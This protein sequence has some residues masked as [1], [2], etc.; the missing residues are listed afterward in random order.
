MNRA[1]SLFR[2]PA[3]LLALLP[4][5]LTVLLAARP[6]A[7]QSVDVRLSGET[8]EQQATSFG[9]GRAFR[10]GS[11]VALRV[12]VAPS[13]DGFVGSAGRTVLVQW[14]V[15]NADGDI[16][17]HRRLVTLTPGR[18]R[19]TWLYAT[20]PRID[21][22]QLWTLRVF[23]APD[24]AGARGAEVGSRIID[25]PS[26]LV[27]IPSGA[28]AIGVIGTRTMGLGD[29]TWPQTQNGE[30]V[31]TSH[32]NV[33][34]QTFPPREIPDSHVGLGMYDILVWADAD[35]SE[36]TMDRQDALRNWIIGG[37]HLVIVLNQDADDW[38][39][40]DP[41]GSPLRGLVPSRPPTKVEDVS[42]ASLMST[43]T[44][45]EGE[46]KSRDE[47]KPT[48][49]LVFDRIGDE[50]DELDAGWIPLIAT[51]SGDVIVVQRPAGHGRLTLIGLDMATD[52]RYAAISLENGLSIGIPQ[53]DA[54]WNRVLGRRGTTVSRGEVQALETQPRTQNGRQVGE[55]RRINARLHQARLSDGSTASGF[56]VM[57]EEAGAGLLLALVLFA[58]YWVVA[59]PGGYA[60]LRARG[61]VRHAWVA[62]VLAA[63]VFTG[64]AWGGV[65]SLR[66]REIDVR[67]LTVLD[68]VAD[69]G[70][71]PGGVPQLA[72]A[73][74]WMSLYLPDYGSSRVGLGDPGTSDGHAMIRSWTP[75]ARALPPAFPN[76]DRYAVDSRDLAAPIAM[77]ARA[78]VTQLKADWVGPLDE[79]FAGMLQ[80]SSA[81]PVRV[82]LNESGFGGRERLRGQVVN[83]LPVALRNVHVFWVHNDRPLRT[84]YARPGG[85]DLEGPLP[86]L[87]RMSLAPRNTEVWSIRGTVAPGAAFQI[88]RPSA[89][90]TGQ[91]NSVVRTALRD[92]VDD[93]W[94]ATFKRSG[95][96]LLA[97]NEP[98]VPR[99][100][101]GIET[102]LHMLS[103]F[104]MLEPPIWL[105]DGSRRPASTARI[106]RRWGRELDL[107][108]WFTRPC[109]I[110]TGFLDASE[111]PYPLE[112][113]GRRVA[114]EGTVMVRWIRPLPVLESLAFEEELTAME[115]IAAESAD[116]EAEELERAADDTAAGES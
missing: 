8:P 114:G 1:P 56:I 113:D 32:D 24:A 37:G 11:P 115:T 74:S 88:G 38:S 14:E 26:G 84:R 17:E 60:L 104:Q 53:A 66:K 13:V 77:P 61:Q 67:H 96:D 73:R 105:E 54:F 28:T 39:L 82:E 6:A 90:P 111:L 5:L 49:L 10:D 92:T 71:G 36:L 110:V 91:P 4:V 27:R 89:G 109:V 63:A 16:A 102:S 23:D 43:L 42:F 22:D 75:E 41:D 80:E 101:R 85:Q 31:P 2:S 15:A 103:I 29:L 46:P 70:N 72:R 100:A 107:S 44:K 50:V 112:V 40:E 79:A 58:I 68:W 21:P 35:P 45:S 51:D 3:S 69:D 19:S 83:Q 116:A 65:T 81:D 47:I 18:T 95:T 20:P 57:S 9:V 33:F 48:Q 52:A 76:A 12:E 78:T 59:G 86:L 62:Y 64:L 30:G 25:V 99:G 108:A 34:I 87:G 97:S 55:Q 98:T 93:R 106:D 94:M 7:A